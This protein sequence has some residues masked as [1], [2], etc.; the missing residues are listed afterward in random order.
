M[1]GFLFA[2]CA[3]TP[4]DRPH[5]SVSVSNYR[6]MLLDHDPVPRQALCA[7]LHQAGMTNITAFADGRSALVDLTGTHCDL[8]ITELKLPGMDGIEFLHRAAIHDVGAFA[9]VSSAAP[10][11]TSAVACALKERGVNLLGVYPKP[12]T[13][14]VIKTLLKRWQDQR[15]SSRARD[16]RAPVRMAGT[17]AL[18]AAL[19]AA[20]FKPFYQP[21]IDIATGNVT[22]VEVLARWQRPNGD[23]DLPGSF[24]PPM[25]YTPMIDRLAD[26]LVEQALADAADWG[27][28]DLTIAI[29]L[30]PHSLQ[31]ITLPDR[32]DARARRHGVAPSR[33]TLELTET[34]TASNWHFMRDSIARLRLRDFNIAIDDF[35]IGYSSMATLLCLPFTELKIDRSFV[36]QLAAPGKAHTILES[37]IRLGRRLDMAVVAEGVETHL[38]LELLRSLGCPAAQGFHI[39]CPMPQSELKHWLGRH[40]DTWQPDFRND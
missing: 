20:E 19:N 25:E 16:L 1:T 35:G 38:E 14:S 6:V 24:I 5:D 9:I 40:R 27:D 18:E 36:A 26:S 12:L 22:G 33:I 23:I 15:K 31:D 11:I 28:E 29:N 13:M 37:M 4:G 10:A 17:A 8:V 3:D 39:A 30:A 34:S 32:L 21:K 7:A 2:P